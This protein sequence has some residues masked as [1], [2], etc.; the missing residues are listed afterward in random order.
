VLHAPSLSLLLF[1]IIMGSCVHS[2]LLPLLMPFD[3]KNPHSIV[4]M[5]N[6]DANVH[7]VDGIMDLIT[8]VGALLSCFPR[9]H[10]TI[11]PLRRLFN[12]LIK[13]YEEEMELK[14]MDMM[15]VVLTALSHITKEDCQG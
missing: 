12:T 2:T 13:A 6:Y 3:G 7:H 5:D 9:T 15:A 14:H 4:V 8:G 1:I 10:P 11:I